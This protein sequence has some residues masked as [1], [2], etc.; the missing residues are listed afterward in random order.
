MTELGSTSSE[1]SV[2]GQDVQ[3]ECSVK[4]YWYRLSGQTPDANF[5]VT[6]CE[7]GIRDWESVLYALLRSMAKVRSV[8]IRHR[9]G[10]YPTLIGS[11]YEMVHLK[12]ACV[13]CFGRECV[14]GRVRSDQSQTQSLSKSLQQW[15]WKG[16]TLK[17][18][19]VLSARSDQ[20]RLI[21]SPYWTL[22]SSEY[23]RS[24][25]QSEPV[26]VHW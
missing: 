16:Y 19:C 24:S 15:I 8:H 9:L 20:I 7:T 4:W 3:T 18:V 11:H 5:S 26:C 13:V 12:R 17:R 21:L 1:Q 6:E 14:Q 2:W 10:L 23:E 22:F 25:Y